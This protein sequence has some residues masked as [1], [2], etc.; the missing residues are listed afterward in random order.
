MGQRNAWLEFIDVGSAQRAISLD[1][2]VVKSGP[3]RVSSSKT[4]IH[5]AGWVAEDVKQKH[6][7]EQRLAGAINISV[8]GVE[9][10][11]LLMSLKDL[12]ISTG[13]ACTSASLE[14]SHVLRAIGLPDELAH[15]SLRLSFGRYTSAA[16]VNAAVAQ[17]R[18][19]AS[20]GGSV[21]TR[22]SWRRSGSTSAM[23]RSGEVSAR[24]S[25]ARV[26]R[27]RPSFGS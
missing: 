16:D 3:V 20:R 1:G 7:L 14:P 9:G 12:A 6:H 13:S 27:P 25:I 21:M 23:A 8:G 19:M 18:T 2:H 11:V 10:E 5:S 15:S 17:L 22:R 26:R 4:P 24:S